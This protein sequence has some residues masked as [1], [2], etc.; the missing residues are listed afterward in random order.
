MTS[1]TDSNQ[2]AAMKKSW[3][4]H[5]VLLVG[6]CLAGA[7]LVFV[8]N[9]GCTTRPRAP[10]IIEE[11]IYN[12]VQEGFRFYPPDGWRCHGRGEFPPI[13]LKKERLLVEYKRLGTKPATLIVSA[14]DLPEGRTVSEYLKSRLLKS[15]KFQLIDVEQLNLNSRTAERHT[16]LRRMNQEEITREVVAIRR[17]QRTYFFT[18]VFASRDKQGKEEIRNAIGSLIC[19]W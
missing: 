18:G 1:P 8:V 7:G 10:A 4:R 6:V 5:P 3:W 11:P 9:G 15:D 2:E 16:Y 19:T 14:V 13:D 12:N 17:K